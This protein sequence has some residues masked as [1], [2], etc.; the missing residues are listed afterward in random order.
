[1]SYSPTSLAAA[2]SN[3]QPTQPQQAATGLPG[4]Q[5]SLHTVVSRLSTFIELETEQIQSEQ[6]FDFRA[7]SEKKS[8]LLLF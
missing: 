8:R 7:S 2:P 1:M 3:T 5:T 6:K 4:Q